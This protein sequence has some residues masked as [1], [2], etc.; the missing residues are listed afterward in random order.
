MPKRAG[1]ADEK[2]LAK[3]IMNNKQKMKEQTANVNS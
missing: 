2:F 3:W 1:D